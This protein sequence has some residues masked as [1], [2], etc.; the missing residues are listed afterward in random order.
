VP[1]QARAAEVLEAWREAER[2]RDKLPEGRAERATVDAEVTELRA[3]YLRLFD[4]QKEA[5]TS[6]D[7]RPTS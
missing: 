3:E 2:R 4:L 6:G 5:G 7:E 1:Y